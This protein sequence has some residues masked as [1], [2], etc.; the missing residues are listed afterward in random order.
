L[1]P[2]EPERIQECLLI[3]KDLFGH[4]FAYS[5]HLVPVIGI[6]DHVTVLLHDIENGKII[7]GEATQ[8]PGRFVLI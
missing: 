2:V 8:A 7:R 6:E 5:D 1:V 3:S 4:K